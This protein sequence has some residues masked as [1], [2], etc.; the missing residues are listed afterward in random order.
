M[1]ARTEAATLGSGWNRDPGSL[2]MVAAPQPITEFVAWR[3]VADSP[4]PDRLLST[5]LVVVGVLVIGLSAT[6]LLI[7]ENRHINTNRRPG[8]LETHESSATILQR[9]SIALLTPGV[10]LPDDL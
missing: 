6:I 2:G 10:T 1:D 4:R 7:V 5:G 9:I 8:F 3:I